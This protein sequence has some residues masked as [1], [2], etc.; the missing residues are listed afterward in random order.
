MQNGHD[1]KDS[2]IERRL[3]PYNGRYETLEQMME[4]GRRERAQAVRQVLSNIWSGFKRIVPGANGLLARWK[5][6]AT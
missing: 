3:N 5:T 1:T 6:Q 4:N 2:M